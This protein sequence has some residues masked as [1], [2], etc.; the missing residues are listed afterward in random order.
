MGHAPF[1]LLSLT[2]KSLKLIADSGCWGRP[3]AP[4]SRVELQHAAINSRVSKDQL[5]VMFSRG[6]YWL[7]T[8]N[9]YS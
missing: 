4:F 1:A 7:V 8:I 2:L 3:A 5:S 6:L 9:S